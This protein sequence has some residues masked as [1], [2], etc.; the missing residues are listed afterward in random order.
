[1]LKK[2]VAT[3]K[4]LLI[5]EYLK[6]KDK[7]D[8]YR[9]QDSALFARRKPNFGRGRNQKYSRHPENSRGARVQQDCKSP[10]KFQQT[11]ARQGVQNKDGMVCY[12]CNQVGH[13]VRNCPL[14]RSNSKGEHSNVA[15][16][17][18]ALISSTEPTSEWFIDSAATKHMT[19]DKSL[20]MN[21]IQYKTPTDIYLGDNTAIKAMGEGM[22]KLPMGTDFH[23]ELHKVLYVPKL[24]KNLLSVPAMISMGAEVKFKNEECIVSKEDKDYVIG[25]LVNGTLYTVNT[26]EL[27]QSATDQTAEVCHQRLG[28]LNNNSV[29]QLAKKGMVTG[30]NCTTS[31]HAE[32]KCEGCVLGKSHRNPFPK[33]SNNRATRLYEIIHS[34]VC[35]PMQVESKGGSHYMVT[36]TDDYSRYTTV[37]FIKR[38]DEVLSKFQEYV[39]F[40]ENQSGNRG[41]VKVLRSD[42]GGEYVS[43]NFIKYCAEKG[44]M[45][46]LTSPYCPE[47]NGVVERLNRT[48]MESA[49]SMIYHA[50]LPLDFW[51]EA[52]NTA[53]YIHNRSPTTCLKDKTPYDCL[54]GKKP[55]V[56][57]LPVLGCKCYVH[58]PNSNR[59]KLDQK[60][61]EAIFI[62]YKD[63]TK[64]YKDYD[65]KRNRF[66]ISHDV[67]FF[68]S[69]FPFCEKCKQDGV[70]QKDNTTLIGDDNEENEEQ[71]HE[72]IERSEENV[73]REIDEVRETLFEPEDM[74]I[75]PGK[76]ESEVSAETNYHQPEST[77]NVEQ[78]G[79]MPTQSSSKT[80]EDSFMENVRNLGPMSR[81]RI[82][83]RFSDDA[84]PAIDSLTLEIDEPN[85]I[86]DA[87]NS[88]HSKHWKDAMITEYTSWVYKVKRNKD[89][90]VDR[91]KARLVAQGYTQTRGTD[92]EEVFSPAAKHTSLRTL[93]ALAN[94]H[95]LEIHQMDVKTAFL[96]GELDYDIYMSQ[97]EGFVDEDKP[98]YVFK[99][100]RSIYGLKLSARCWNT[101]LDEYLKSAGYHKSGADG[102]IYVKSIKNHDGHLSFVILGV[103]VDDLIPVSN[104]IDMLNSEKAALCQRFKMDDRGEAHYLLGMLIKRDRRAKTL[105]VSQQRYTEKVLK[106]FG[107]ESCKPIATP[108]EPGKKF[109]ELSSHDESFDTQTYQ[110]AIGCLT[111]MSVTTRPDIAAAVGI[112]S[113]YMSKPS[114][115]HWMGVKRALRYLKGTMNHGINILATK[116]R[117][118]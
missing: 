54:F 98:N 84:C 6:R 99:L 113:Q 106:R 58:I 56:S 79:E 4:G 114:K 70:M 63:G 7:S 48:I 61:Y 101:T 9:S 25:K 23:L 107:M 81:R 18:I 80:Y 60:S 111:Y 86:E 1:M 94:E 90:S 15:E 83:K 52:C 117:K 109:H 53:V 8:G 12:K 31:Q 96:N 34:D 72:E 97:P 87:L 27:A 55:N 30:M 65:V 43:N 118:T 110:Q 35:G 71:N 36:F 11:V 67:T 62:S 2:W 10:D 91:F 44:I 39:T 5:E 38:K 21:Y 73:E 22:V 51:A 76:E 16:G 100:K 20:L 3:I 82:P 64:G 33:Q 89:G 28:H 13:I 42:N 49:R 77:E 116:K 47:Q 50:G 19:H 24:A 103:Y 85:G 95:D 46:E 105:S 32:S 78:V 92:Y 102:C 40:V 88:E 104:D 57:H 108:L 69:K 112:L 75:N 115:E 59:R 74:T 68:E 93:L 41:H 37:Y 14:N 66:M 45:H 26:I 29:D 17:G